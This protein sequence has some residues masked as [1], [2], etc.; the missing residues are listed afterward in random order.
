MTSQTSEAFALPAMRG[1]TLNAA[2]DGITNDVKVPPGP[3]GGSD[4]IDTGRA[5][6]ISKCSGPQSGRG[7]SR[8]KIAIQTAN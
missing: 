8:G 2:T 3:R 7:L 6:Q 5:G 1:R 4:G